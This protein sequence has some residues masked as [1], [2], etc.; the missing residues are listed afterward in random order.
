MSIQELKNQLNQANSTL[1]LTTEKPSFDAVASAL[2]MYL[3]LKNAGKNVS[4]ASS[5]EPIVRDSHLVGLDKIQTEI[6]STNLAISFP[7]QE[8][9]IEKVSY[10][11]EGDHFK[12]LI[13][14]KEGFEPIKKEDLSF[15]YT[16]AS[17]DLVIIIGASRIEDVGS[18]ILNEKD[19]LEKATIVN[20]S[21]V[22]GSFGKINLVDPNSSLSEIV[23][24]IIQETSL[25]LTKD[26]AQNL[27]QGIEDATQNLRST[28]MTADTFEALALLHRTGARR[29]S[30]IAPTIEEKESAKRIT[31]SIQE[32]TKTKDRGAI[33]KPESPTNGKLKPDWLKPKIYK[34]STKV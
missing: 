13:Q 25:Q 6:G 14:P 21:D 4:I 28:K 8:D 27:M 1:V 33:V 12:L 9:S 20:I 30:R 26:T 5:S 7:Y 17:A 32:Q 18:I 15:N 16:G 2:A 19:L 22:P 34:G 11:V 3:S 10:N 31:Q 23:T 29:S 24:A